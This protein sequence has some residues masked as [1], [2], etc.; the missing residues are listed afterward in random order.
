[1][2][3]PSHRLQPSSPSADNPMHFAAHGPA[4]ADWS[5]TSVTF[6]RIVADSGL[7][8]TMLRATQFYDLILRGAKRLVKLPVIPVPAG[9]VVQPIDPAEV[10]ERL[11]E[12]ALGAPAGRVPRPGRSA[13]V[14]L[15]RPDPRGTCGPA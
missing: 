11:A 2:P 10:A 14:Q 9:F 8:W 7:P 12:L 13:G 5:R 3:R 6:P 1:M 4:R 15:C